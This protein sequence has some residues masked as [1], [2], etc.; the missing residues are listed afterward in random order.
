VG[1]GYKRLAEFNETYGLPLTC[2]TGVLLFAMGVATSVEQSK[3]STKKYNAMYWVQNGIAPVPTALKPLTIVTKTMGEPAGAVAA[4][5]L[6][7]C[8][9]VMDIANGGLAFAEDAA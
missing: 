2:A 6:M 9:A 1:S 8:D 5:I 7:A 3:D 4:G